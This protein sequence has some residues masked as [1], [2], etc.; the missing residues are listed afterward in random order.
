MA[1]V[2]KAIEHGADGGRIAQQLV[3]RHLVETW[4]ST[5]RS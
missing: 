5:R 2:E 1:V 4:S 3:L